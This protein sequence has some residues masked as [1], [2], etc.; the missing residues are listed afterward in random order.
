LSYIDKVEQLEQKNREIHNKEKEMLSFFTHTMRNALATAPE[1]L[2]QAIYLL[3]GEDYEKD[4][5]HYKAVNK[6]AAL[7]SALSLTDCLI[8]TFK[9]SISDPQEFKRSWQVDHSGE[10]TPEWVI[11]SALRQALNRIIFMSDTTE[12]RK[13]L[14][15]QETALVKATRKSFIE[16]VLPLELNNHG[17]QLF[18]QWSEDHIPSVNVVISGTENLNFGINQTRFSLLFAITSELILNA[19]KYW[20]GEN[21]IE[22]SW[23]LVEQKNY[24]FSVVNHCRKNASSNLAGTHKGLAFIRRLIELLGSQ[25]DFVCKSDDQVFIAEL[26]LNKT[27]FDQQL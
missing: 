26:F 7:F 21:S 18:S 13:L 10:A 27:L 6:I 2:R 17:I 4:T 15:S 20:D 12:L 19:L 16:E 24:V 9:Q 8:D 22:I 23:Q 5:K 11:S 25:A 3:G 14:N 1:S